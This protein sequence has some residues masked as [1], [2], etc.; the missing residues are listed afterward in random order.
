MHFMFHFVAIRPFVIDAQLHNGR[1]NSKKAFFWK[2]AKICLFT[3]HVDPSKF[4]NLQRFTT[5]VLINYFTT[6]STC[7]HDNE[8]FSM[9]LFMLFRYIMQY[10][11]TVQVYLFLTVTFY[12]YVAFRC[13]S[14][15]SSTDC[16][17]EHLSV[18]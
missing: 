14:I 18:R 10:Y 9:N 4:I 15:Y 17:V 11:A 2:I 7:I 12:R 1:C 8:N 16:S 5:I 3:F 13:I 6:C